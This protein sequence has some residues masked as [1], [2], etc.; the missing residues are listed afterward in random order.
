MLVC[1]VLCCLLD[2]M[3]FDYDLGFIWGK[4]MISCSL[5]AGFVLVCLAMGRSGYVVFTLFCSSASLMAYAYHVFGYQLTYDGVAALFETNG[6]ELSGFMTPLLVGVLVLAIAAPAGLFYLLRKL[7]PLRTVKVRLIVGTGAAAVFVFF[8]NLPELMYAIRPSIYQRT[9]SLTHKGL[10]EM[11][12]TGHYELSSEHLRAPFSK[13]EYAIEMVYVYLTQPTE[14]TPVEEAPSQC[15]GKLQ[16]D[17]VI[18]FVIGESVRAATAHSTA[19][20]NPPWRM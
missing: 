1:Y 11:F 9:C 10:P 15:D 4:W 2:Y 12:E 5:M 14:F 16:E 18:V 13:L 17:L 8:F 7:I 3:F 6:R 19:T 20:A